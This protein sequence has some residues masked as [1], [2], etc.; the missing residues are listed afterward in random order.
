MS[1]NVCLITSPLPPNIK[2]VQILVDNFIEILEPIS[3]KIYLITGNYHKNLSKSQFNLINLKLDDKKQ[4]TIIRT[5]K[6]I[7]TQF[8]MSYELLKIRNKI[9]VVI[10]FISSPFA[11]P[12]L[13]AKISGKRAI[14]IVT[15]SSPKGAKQLYKKSF[16]GIGSMV[17]PKVLNFLEKINYHFSDDII[18]LSE[19]L[20]NDIGLAKYK[21]KINYACATFVDL[22]TFSI[23]TELKERDNIVGFIGRLTETKGIMQFIKAIHILSE[24]GDL[25]FFIGGDGRLREEVENELSKAD[26]KHLATFKGWIPHDELS[27]YLNLLKLIV[28]PSYTEAFPAVGLE[29]MACGTPVLITPVGGVLDIIKDG[30][31]GFIMEN[32]S[33]EVIA[34]NIQRALNYPDLDRVVT[35][36]RDLMENNFSYE[37][38]TRTYEMIIKNSVKK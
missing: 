31:T 18:V 37:N 38:V 7:I 32:N 21:K 13:T 33:P 25:S 5:P 17:F 2:G 27:K 11:V 8:K 19:E 9:D 29:A 4:S 20:V 26:L 24:E 15:G 23:I 35:N 36:A 16:F 12:L 10:F 14:M 6:F 30:E 22:K 28:V 34:K 1:F 3:D